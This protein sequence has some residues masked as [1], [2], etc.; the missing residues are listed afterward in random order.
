MLIVA[1]RRWFVCKDMY[2][3]Y[4][5]V[6]KKSKNILPQAHSQTNDLPHHHV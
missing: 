6:S 4:C 3:N 2:L 5:I 1:F